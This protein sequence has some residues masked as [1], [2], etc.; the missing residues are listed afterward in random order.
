MFNQNYE[1]EETHKNANNFIEFKLK[2]LADEQQIEICEIDELIDLIYEST[3]Y[4]NGYKKHLP[5]LVKK[6]DQTPDFKI[7]KLFYFLEKFYD[8][9]PSDFEIKQRSFQQVVFHL[10]QLV[11]E[12][13]ILNDMY[14][15]YFKNAY[16]T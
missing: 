3:H 12:F 14:H 11:D 2:K 6:L 10:A 15:A 1:I 8:K 5:L 4:L 16:Y 9:L 13:D 7:L